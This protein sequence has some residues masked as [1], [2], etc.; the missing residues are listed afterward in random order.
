MPARPDPVARG[1]R[2]LARVDGLGQGRRPAGQDGHAVDGRVVAEQ[3]RVL[4]QVVAQV[5]EAGGQVAT[6]VWTG[7]GA[8]AGSGGSGGKCAWE[9]HQDGRSHQGRVTKNTAHCCVLIKAWLGYM[10]FK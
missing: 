8:G 2:Q 9:G 10:A 1:L 4:L 3:V 5:A 6:G 7:S